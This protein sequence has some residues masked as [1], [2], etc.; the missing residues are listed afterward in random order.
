MVKQTK[1][2]AFVL[3]DAARQNEYESLPTEKH[4]LMIDQ[5]SLANTQ[6]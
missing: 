1:G 4:A 6:K 2:C 5:A 3:A